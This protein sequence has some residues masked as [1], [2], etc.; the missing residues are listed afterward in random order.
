[1]KHLTRPSILTAALVACLS[2]AGVTSS[3]QAAEYDVDSSHASVVFRV[4][5]LGLSY[6]YGLFKEVKG[7]MTLDESGKSALDVTI[8]ARSIETGNK[9]RDDHL[10]SPDFFNVNEYPVIRFVSQSVTRTDDGWRVEGQLTMTGVTKP[11]TFTLK[12]LARGKGMQGESRVGM[13]T[14][15]TIS[16][17]DFGITKYEQAI[18]PDVTLLISFEGIA[19]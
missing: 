16:R 10:R 19:K 12:E 15:F 5:H 9:Q 11:L 6:T 3:A 13:E 17:H 1:M 18:G 4:K 7:T 14:S 2:V 8:A